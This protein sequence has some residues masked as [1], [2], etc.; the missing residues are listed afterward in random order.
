M[1]VAELG[2]V[3]DD[4]AEAAAGVRPVAGLAEASTRRGAPRIEN[5]SADGVD[6]RHAHR[7]LD[8]GVVG[9]AVGIVGV[10]GVVAVVGDG[11]VEHG[12]RQPAVGRVERN[13]GREER[14]G[15]RDR[16]RRVAEPDRADRV[17]AAEAALGEAGH[18]GVRGRVVAVGGLRLRGQRAFEHSGVGGAAAVA[19]P[20]GEEGVGERRS[21]AGDA[22]DLPVA[23]IASRPHRDV[24]GAHPAEGERNGPGVG[25][26]VLGRPGERNGRGVGTEMSGRPGERNGR[27]VGGEVSGRGAQVRTPTVSSRLP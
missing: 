21:L 18:A 4:A 27:G 20:D 5:Q 7:D 24:A 11:D 8:V 13:E 15:D 10:V 26:E 17:L 22:L 6:H 3:E 19:Q 12:D 9:V 23:Q 1:T 14:R 16:Q 2:V 25:T